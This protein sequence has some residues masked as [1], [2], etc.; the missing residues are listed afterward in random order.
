MTRLTLRGA[1]G[2]EVALLPFVLANN[3]SA[4]EEVLERV[5]LLPDP[6]FRQFE[7]GLVAYYRR[8][9]AD[10]ERIATALLRRRISPRYARSRQRIEEILAMLEHVHDPMIR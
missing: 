7:Y 6:E 5:E 4:I 10:Q 3:G 1:G 9:E 8:Y 2:T